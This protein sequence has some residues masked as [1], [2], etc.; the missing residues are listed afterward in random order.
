[1]TYILV[2]LRNVGRQC[3]HEADILREIRRQPVPLRQIFRAVVGDPDF[4]LV[5]L[6]NQDLEWQVDGNARCRDHKGSAPLWVTE[7]EKLGRTH[8]HPYLLRFSAVID[9]CEYG[10]S[11][12]LED[13]LELPQGLIDRMLAGFIDDSVGGHAFFPQ[14]WLLVSDVR[15]QDK[16]HPVQNEGGR[17]LRDCDYVSKSG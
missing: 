6:P 3:L 11:L 1:M 14:P 8:F 17:N 5:I 9:E 15:L 7:N 16:S 10:N 13:S 4:P 12:N 2:L